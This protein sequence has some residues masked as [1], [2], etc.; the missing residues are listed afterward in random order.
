MSE[1][2]E[3]LKREVAEMQTVAASAATT[4]NNL[5]AQIRDLKDDPV[6]LGQLADDLDASANALAAAITANTV[7]EDEPEPTEEPPEEDEPSEDD[8]STEDETAV[9]GD[10]RS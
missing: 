10:Q 4:L 2:F 1:Q 5:S 9:S 3:N 7:A 8:G 6:A